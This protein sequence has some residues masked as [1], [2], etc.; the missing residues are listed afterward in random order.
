MLCADRP[1]AAARASRGAAPARGFSLLELLV[2][3]FVVVI[4]TSLVSI[5]VNSGGQDVRLE[6]QVRRFADTALYALDEA[7]FTGTD[8][9]LLLERIP[10]EGEWIYAWSWRERSL[11]G[12]RFP[13][14]GKEVFEEQ[15]LPPGIEAELEIENAPFSEVELESEEESRG[16]Q[17][18]LYASG[19]T[20]VGA[21]NL[22]RVEDG[23]LLWRVEWDLLGRFDV[24]RRGEPADEELP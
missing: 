3:L 12:W 9:G 13:E 1:V 14:S 22:R 8:Y 2:V 23:E 19:E 11:E 18:V 4:I 10:R 20:T 21:L 16:P 6:S 24:L 7:Q 17:V 5:N 15:E